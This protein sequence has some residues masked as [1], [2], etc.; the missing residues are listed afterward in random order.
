MEFARVKMIDEPY[1]QVEFESGKVPVGSRTTLRI[2]I[3]ESTLLSDAYLAQR[4]IRPLAA[5]F[6]RSAGRRGR[7]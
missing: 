7:G 3:T 2:V 6:P 5:I 1:D 4:P